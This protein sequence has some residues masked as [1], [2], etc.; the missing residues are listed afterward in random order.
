MSEPAYYYLSEVCA[1][2]RVSADTINRLVRLGILVA[3]GR[4]AGRRFQGA[5]ARALHARIEQGEDLWQIKADA[6]KAHA[7]APTD[8][9]VSTSMKSAKN[10]TSSRRK[11]QGSARRASATGP[12]KLPP[13]WL[14][15]IG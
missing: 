5:A 13:D 1:M 12:T 6:E 10:G 14:K 9:E 15:R 3:H 4:S 8:T 11:R 7:L 2:F